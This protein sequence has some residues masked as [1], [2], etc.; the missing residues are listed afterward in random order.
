MTPTKIQEVYPPTILHAKSIADP[1]GP[2]DI[3]G[4]SSSQ[5]QPPVDLVPTNPAAGGPIL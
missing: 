2:R 3:Q 5:D 1:R 4:L